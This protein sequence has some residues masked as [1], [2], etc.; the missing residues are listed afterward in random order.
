MTEQDSA[1][2]VWVPGAST[3]SYLH[4]TPLMRTTKSQSNVNKPQKISMLSKFRVKTL[5]FFHDSCLSQDG[6]A[7]PQLILQTSLHSLLLPRICIYL[8]LLF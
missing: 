3:L 8:Y 1:T 6:A 7:H 4:K 5:K 2:H